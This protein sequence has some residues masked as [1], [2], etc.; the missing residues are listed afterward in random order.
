M[1]GRWLRLLCVCALL[2]PSLALA[3]T[4]TV[5]IGETYALTHLPTYVV[6][7][8]KLIEAEAAAR[9]LPP[10]KVDFK[11][12]GN[13]DVVA[14][15]LIS[16]N[17]NVAT[18][19][20][21]PFLFLWSKLQQHDPVKGIASLASSN[22]FLMSRE[23]RIQSLKDYGPDDRIAMTNVRSTTW[24]IV[25]QMAAAKMYGWEDRGH[26]DRISVPMTNGEAVAAMLSSAT[27]VT[28]HFTVLPF[29]EMERASGHIHTVLNSRDVL[30]STIS[31]TV[32]FTTTKF[33]DEN[34]KVYAAIAAAYERADQIIAENP[35][36][37]AEI[38]N[39]Y[40]PQK[41]G[42]PAILKMMAPDTPDE[43]H[44]TTA[45]SAVKAFADFMA[46]TGMI[47][48]SLPDWHDYFFENL[49]KSDGS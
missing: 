22:I 44:F 10:I 46:K 42:V 40:E 45:P 26:F 1:L 28:S 30:G 31:A 2:S 6:V 47:K 14:N 32:A 24:A 38:Y 25:L 11:R 39:R 19:G 41:G 9:G 36:L 7:D 48:S 12:V 49:A 3:E 5:T 23:P 16:G 37:A 27:N 35:Q 8:Q 29:T 33:H 21:V 18:A 20:L 17:I 4:T 15:L 34:P 13:G 43:L